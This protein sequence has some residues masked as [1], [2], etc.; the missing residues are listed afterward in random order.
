MG[1]FVPEYTLLELIAA[2][3]AGFIAGRLVGL[4]SPHRGQQR[5]AVPPARHNAHDTAGQLPPD[6]RQK[7]EELLRQDRYIEAV[8][9]VRLATNMGLK[10]AKD[11][12][13]V[14]NQSLVRGGA[15]A[16]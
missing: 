6:V 10:E 11:T 13:D 14:L 8:R 1:T 4:R 3:I 16:S 2:L 7:V 12:V 15:R 5:P 9:D